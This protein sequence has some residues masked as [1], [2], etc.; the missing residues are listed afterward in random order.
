MTLNPAP[1]FV[2]P[3]LNVSSILVVANTSPGSHNAGFAVFFDPHPTI[4]GVTITGPADV[5]ASFAPGGVGSVVV[6]VDVLGV[7]TT[8]ANAEGSPYLPIPF[9]P[10]EGVVTAP[11]ILPPGSTITLGGGSAVAAAFPGSVTSFSISG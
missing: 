8:V 5:Y 1:A 4:N 9:P 10:G 11:A 2:A 7:V 3:G 6:S